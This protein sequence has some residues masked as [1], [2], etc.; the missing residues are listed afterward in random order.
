MNALYEKI[1]TFYQAPVVTFY[2]NAMTMLVLLVLYAYFLMMDFCY[3]PVL[4]EYLVLVWMISTFSD[5]FRQFY[6]AGPTYHSRY[7]NY[8]NDSW[9]YLDMVIITFY[10]FANV[11][12]I[13]AG[14]LDPA[15]KMY[16]T[17]GIPIAGEADR[18]N[19]YN[20]CDLG[21]GKV[22][23]YNGIF[24]GSISCDYKNYCPLLM[25]SQDQTD[26]LFSALVFH[27]VTFFLLCLRYANFFT[28]ARH[29]GPLI[30]TI[31]RMMGDMGRFL[32]LL[33]VMMVGF[34]VTSSAL[35]YPNSWV[36][37][38]IVRSAF[39]RSYYAIFGELLM[40]EHSYSHFSGKW[41]DYESISPSEAKYNW[42]SHFDEKYLSERGCYMVF[43]KPTD[44][45]ELPDPYEQTDFEHIIRCPQGRG[46]V[47]ILLMFYMLFTNILLLNLLIALFTTTYENTMVEAHQNWRFQRTGLV[48]EY[49]NRPVYPP[50]FI[51]VMYVSALV[52]K[53]LKTVKK[54][55]SFNVVDQGFGREEEAADVAVFARRYTTEII[56][57]ISDKLKRH[58][59]R[60]ERVSADDVLSEK[61]N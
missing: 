7:I 6:R 57:N 22:D 56:F 1:A 35:M 21:T 18:I 52:K 39:Y 29:L 10:V 49:K 44:E 53:F 24:N 19:V 8:F 13:C 55:F 33:F 27:C 11:L 38:K 32:T 43:A 16:R 40:D 30:L 60:L 51:L 45:E 17:T 5:E 46:F 15:F 34:G 48:K 42:A 28:I 58:L 20:K 2:L 26:W 41:V 3:V 25:G 54:L 36:G 37:W 9:N 23:Y 14:F 12:R 31:M 50:P 4:A 47:D 61:G 59:A